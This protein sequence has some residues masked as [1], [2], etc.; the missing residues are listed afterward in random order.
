MA[1][2]NAN[3][4]RFTDMVA[5][6][7]KSTKG[8]EYVFCGISGTLS[9]IEARTIQAKDGQSHNVVSGSMCVNRRNGRI[10]RMIGTNLP[11]GTKENPVTEET[12]V[13][14]QFWD[15]ASDRLTHFLSKAGIPTDGSGKARV[16]VFGTLSKNNYT[17]KNGQAREGVQMSAS[18][19]WVMPRGAQGNN[20]VAGDNVPATNNDGFFDASASDFE[21]LSADDDGDVPF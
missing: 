4:N 18:E 10:N 6:N 21:V 9:R 7:A 5:V 15:A 1:N 17:D 14:I 13:R 11:V 19:F 2:N 3:N 20:G 8:A 16:A 12:W